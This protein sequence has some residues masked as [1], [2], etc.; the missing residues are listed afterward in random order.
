MLFLLLL[1][2]S[3]RKVPC[4]LALTLVMVLTC[5]IVL[6]CVSVLARVYGVYLNYLFYGVY[7]RHKG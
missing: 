6:A 5:A 1:L 2:L 7:Q 3:Y 4:V